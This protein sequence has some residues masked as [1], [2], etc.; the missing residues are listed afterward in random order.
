MRL[1]KLGSVLNMGKI[2]GRCGEV[3]WSFAERVV[4]SGGDWELVLG[5]GQGFPCFGPWFP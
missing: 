5:F 3:G 2:R 1:G 4:S